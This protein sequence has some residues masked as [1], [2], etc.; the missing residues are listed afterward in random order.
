MTILISLP[1]DR[2][3]FLVLGFTMAVML[4]NE[5]PNMYGRK[6]DRVFTEEDF[7]K[8]H[9]LFDEREIFDFI[10]DIK[11]PEHPMSLEELGVVELELI[12]LNEDSK[13]CLV[14]FKPTIPHCSMATL[15]GLAIKVHLLRLMPISFKVDVRIPPGYHNSYNAINKQLADKERVS[16]ALENQYLLGVINDCLLLSDPQDLPPFIET[17]LKDSKKLDDPKIKYIQYSRQHIESYRRWKDIINNQTNRC[18]LTYIA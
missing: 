16:A 12:Q 13:I 10:R 3:S 8:S 6:T 15:I 18:H 4:Q 9:I 17:A 5:F 7:N 14:E 11:D 2:G 1:R